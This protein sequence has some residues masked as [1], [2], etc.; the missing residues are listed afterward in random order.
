MD[1]NDKSKKF[2]YALRNH[3]YNLNKLEKNIQILFIYNRK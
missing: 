2:A 1:L 3:D